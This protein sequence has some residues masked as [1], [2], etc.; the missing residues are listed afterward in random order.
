MYFKLTLVVLC[1]V[2]S[3]CVLTL[4]S[5]CHA[6]ELPLCRLYRL[7]YSVLNFTV[8]FHHIPV[9]QEWHTLLT[10]LEISLTYVYSGVELLDHLTQDF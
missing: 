7:C 9:S 6:F 8:L 1:G 10:S 2:R 4:F 3:P 5:E